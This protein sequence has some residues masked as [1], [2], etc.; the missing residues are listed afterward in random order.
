MKRIQTSDDNKLLEAEVLAPLKQ[1]Y[2]SFTKT[3][4]KL[5][6]YLLSRPNCLILETASTIASNVGVSPMTV[7][8]FLRKLGFDGISDIRDRLKTDLYGPDGHTL[9][10]I[11]RRY[12]AFAR[13]R[14]QKFSRDDSL[15]A[16]LAA[17]RQAYEL[18]TTPLWKDVVGSL[19]AADRIYV[20]GLHMARPMALELVTRFEYIRPGVH[21]SDGQ[22]GHYGDVLNEP[23]RRV[24]LILIDFYRYD[25][26]TQKL[27]QLAKEQGIDVI[28][29][30]DTYCLWAREVTDR[31][32]GLPTGTGLFW[33]STAAFTTLLNLMVDDVIQRLGDRVPKRIDKIFHAQ[34]LFDQFA[35]DL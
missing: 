25:R 18:T 26:A 7:G 9:W 22:N 1:N 33:H 31:V 35:E 6:S 32:F 5:A 24:S 29:V 8:R 21:L 4:K 10:S 13:R 3:E 16:E 34:E 19:T 14:A 11:D 17:I 27:A 20:S 30:T 2:E 12:E 15:A 28:I 23:A